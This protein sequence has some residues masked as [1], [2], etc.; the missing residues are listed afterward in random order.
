MATGRRPSKRPGHARKQAR[1]WKLCQYIACEQG[2]DGDRKRFLGTKQQKY[3][4]PACTA[5]ATRPLDTRKGDRQRY[6][7]GSGRKNRRQ[8]RA[9]EAPPPPPDVPPPPPDMRT[10][11]HGNGQL[12]TGSP[13]GNKGNPKGRP[14]K[15]LRKL[16]RIIAGSCGDAL[17]QRFTDDPQFE[18]LSTEKLGKLFVDTMKIAVG[19]PLKIEGAGAGGAISVSV[20]GPRPRP[21]AP[22][23]QEQPPQ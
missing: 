21:V 11:A 14:R 22:P 10:P 18:K 8:L 13:P 16:A 17:V 5:A 19:Q 1:R 3:C 9:G 7:K 20:I 6:V 2:E 23:A 15:E 4:C 12:N